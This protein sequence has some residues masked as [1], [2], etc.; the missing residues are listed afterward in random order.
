MSKEWRWWL[1]IH[2]T[3]AIA[4][5]LVV[6]AIVQF[7]VPDTALD[8]A[9]RQNFAR[10]HPGMTRADVIEI[11]GPPRDLANR[12]PKPSDW[13]KVEPNQVQDILE[14]DSDHLRFFV[15]FDPRDSSAAA[16]ATF[17]SGKPSSANTG[18]LSQRLS[19]LAKG[20]LSLLAMSV[21]VVGLACFLSADVAMLQCLVLLVLGAT[22]CLFAL[23]LAASAAH[24]P[25]PWGISSRGWV[26]LALLTL[27]GSVLGVREAHLL[28]HGTVT[29]AANKPTN[30]LQD[31]AGA[32]SDAPSVWSMRRYG[33]NPPDINDAGAERAR[34]ERE[35]FEARRRL[36]ALESETRAERPTEKT[37]VLAGDRS[38]VDTSQW[39]HKP[40]T[41]SPSGGAAGPDRV[42]SERDRLVKELAD[43]QKRIA[44][45]EG[46]KGPARPPEKET[47]GPTASPATLDVSTWHHPAQ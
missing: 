13:P 39:N 10:I 30:S 15:Y 22:A 7:P 40:E 42:Q 17:R 21:G 6:L 14:W 35:L 36:V 12:I 19:P 16:A 27:A 28:A 37:P 4:L 8:Q 45:L 25:G 38:V 1:L 44:D 3:L 20:T 31:S 11:L 34:L 41:T 9:A 46:G 5:V 29:A 24:D 32:V 2:L 23:P 26:S 18:P 47:F 43:A 33:P